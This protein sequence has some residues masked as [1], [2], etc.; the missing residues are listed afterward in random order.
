MYAVICQREAVFG[1]L[2]GGGS[3]GRFFFNQSV[4]YSKV[5]VVFAHDA[6]KFQKFFHKYFG[7]TGY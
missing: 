5:D 7:D 1:H 6:P 4:N 2:S 3:F